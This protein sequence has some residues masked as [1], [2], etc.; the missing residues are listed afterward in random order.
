M[1]VRKKKDPRLKE[2]DDPEETG[3]FF[4]WRCVK[5]DTKIR[6]ASFVGKNDEA[7]AKGLLVKVEER[8]VKLNDPLFAGADDPLFVSDGDR[9]IPP[10]MLAVFC[11]QV[12]EGVHR[13]PKWKYPR[14]EPDEHVIFVRAIKQ[15]DQNGRLLGL[16]EEVTWGEEEA[17]WQRIDPEGEGGHLWTDP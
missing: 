13:G 14:I 11:K 6:V 7:G 16:V 10:A 8:M 4:L 1:D 5:R 15:R 2:A 9:S 17:V 12:E 3:E